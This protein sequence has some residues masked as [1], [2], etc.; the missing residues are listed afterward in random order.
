MKCIVCKVA[1]DK[2]EGR[3]NWAFSSDRTTMAKVQLLFKLYDLTRREFPPGS[4][5]PACYDLVAQI[6]TLEY[7]VAEMQKMLKARINCCA[8]QVI[9]QVK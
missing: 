4:I 1:K 9:S 3:R 8:T 2:G 7:Q 6:D 5:C